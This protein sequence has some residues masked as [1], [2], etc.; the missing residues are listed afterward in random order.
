MGRVLLLIKGTS[1]RLAT[2]GEFW[3]Q[4]VKRG[5]FT[6]YTLFSCLTC[7]EGHVEHTDNLDLQ[8][9]IV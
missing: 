8:S 3:P 2:A 4:L 6:N 1:H 7:S 5:I 9:K